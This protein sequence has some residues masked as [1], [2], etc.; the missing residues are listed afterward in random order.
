MQK[1][2]LHFIVYWQMGIQGGGGGR[3]KG[4][5]E[6]LLFKSLPYRI[7]QGLVL[8]TKILR[9]EKFSLKVRKC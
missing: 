6:M 4:A 8:S 9:S 5:V 3:F 2:C 1:V 7:I